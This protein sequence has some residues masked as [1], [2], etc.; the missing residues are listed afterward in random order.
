MIAKVE[1]PDGIELPSDPAKIQA[2]VIR[3]MIEHEN[4]IETMPTG[5]YDITPIIWTRNTHNHELTVLDNGQGL[6]RIFPKV[7]N[8]GLLQTVATGGLGGFKKGG[9]LNP[10][11]K[12]SPLAI[13]AG[14][15]PH[16]PRA[17]IFGVIAHLMD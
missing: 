14:G 15:H 11:N 10:I 4:D 1:F 7:E 17:Q 13:V 5:V 16:K 12:E 2:D 8:A 9:I 3:M 6:Y